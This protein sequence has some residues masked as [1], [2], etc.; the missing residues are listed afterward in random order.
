[1]VN[2]MKINN[3]FIIPWSGVG[4]KYTE[5][6]IATVVDCMKN[7]DPMTQGKY[8]KEFEE[9][10]TKYCGSKAS[11]AVNTATGALELAALV[12]NLKK[13][14]EV[15]CPAHTFCASAIPFARTG[16]TIKWADIELE[17]RVVSIDTISPLITKNTKVIIVVHLY[18]LMVDMDPIMK[19][20]REKN[21]IVVEDA[22]QAPGASYKGKKAGSIGDLGVFSFHTHKNISTLGEGG[23]LT[24]N[25]DEFIKLIPGLRHN[26]VRA[27]ENQKVYWQPG[28]S[29]VD[30][31]IDGVWPYNFC[32]GE[33]QC[34]LG[35]KM[36]D[37]LDDLN[38]LRRNRAM[39][40]IDRLAKYDELKFQ[41]AKNSECEN[42]WHL[43]I[44]LYE[45][46]KFG[47]N[48]DDFIT[49]IV[50]DHKV[51]IIRPYYPLYK[52]P[53]FTKSGMGDANCPN[54]EYYFE[55]ILAFPF[56]S[57]MS[58]EQFNYMLDAIEKTLIKLRK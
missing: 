26:G 51:K 3:E 48:T 54:L 22:A 18:G 40:A 10:F 32:L 4:A 56:Q 16:A 57:W 47:S 9:K 1:M 34:A 43:L 58:D 28:M 5:D 39:M 44:G 12:S 23:M 15:I 21:I 38:N 29:N 2:K 30:F 33:I 55:R 19:L 20:A 52:Y 35:S 17:T 8:Q 37:R 49:T 25:R 36:L 24:V 41:K 50:N 42:V 6:E 7:S 31:D 11:F 46:E 13:G 14:D 27:F 53:I 45:G